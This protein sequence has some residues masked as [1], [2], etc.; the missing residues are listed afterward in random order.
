MSKKDPT[1]KVSETQEKIQ[2]SEKDRV[3]IDK[4]INNKRLSRCLS[5]HWLRPS[6][7]FY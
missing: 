7:Y 6:F 4:N 3:R 1:R 5:G 2:A